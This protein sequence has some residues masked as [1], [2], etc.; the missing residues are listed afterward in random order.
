[1]C[2]RELDWDMEGRILRPKVIWQ[3]IVSDMIPVSVISEE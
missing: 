3:A 2:Y 1:M